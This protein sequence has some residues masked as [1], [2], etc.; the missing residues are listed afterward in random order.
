MQR[1]EALGVRLLP[2][3][4]AAYVPIIKRCATESVPAVDAVLIDD[5]PLVHMAWNMAAKRAGKRVAFFKAPR[6]FLGRQAYLSADVPLYVDAQLGELVQ[7]E[8]F[9]RELLE[10]GF[11]NVILATGRDPAAFAHLPWIT[12]VVGKEPPF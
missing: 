9:A 5:D 1:C 4:V 6:E 2:K 10:S 12:Q 3:P 11:T 8:Q 7:G